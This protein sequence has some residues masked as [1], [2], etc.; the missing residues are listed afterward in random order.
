VNLADE[1]ADFVGSVPYRETSLPWGRAQVW[2]LGEGRPVVAIHGIAGGRRILFRTVP[3]MAGDR[4]VI[5][6]P[7]RGEDL[8]A[9]DAHPKPYLDDIAALLEELDLR[10]VTLFGVSFGGYLALAYGGRNDPRVSDIVVQGTFTRYRL[11]PMDRVTLYASYLGPAAIG[12]YYFKKRTLQGRE[13]ALVKELAPGLEPLVVD[14]MGKTP[15][16]SIRSRTRMIARHSVHEAAKAIRVPLTLAHGRQDPVVPFSYF[17]RLRA[18]LD[19]QTVEWDDA[20]HLVP[21]TH[22]DRI[23]GLLGTAGS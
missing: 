18:T 6:P 1:F 5:V 8:P 17:E 11:K 15:F 3:L 7:L 19:A 23:A 4:R 10:D 16:K 14:W 21:L 22:P 20:A 12:T 2:D 13:H 9:L